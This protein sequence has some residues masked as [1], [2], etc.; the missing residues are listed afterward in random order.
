MTRIRNFVTILALACVFLAIPTAIRAQRGVDPTGE[1]R[2]VPLPAFLEQFKN[3]DPRIRARAF[4]SLLEPA[5]RANK[6]V[7]AE[8]ASEREL[9]TDALIALLRREAA[10]MHSPPTGENSEEFLDYVGD[11]VV[12]VA[13]LDSPKAVEALIGVIETGWGAMNG[14]VRLGKVA[15]PSLLRVADS[16]S[17][18]VRASAA[19]T[20]GRM[21][22]KHAE[23]GLGQND[24]ANIRT[25]LLARSADSDPY[26]R[27]GAIRSLMPFRDKEVMAAVRRAAEDSFAQRNGGEPVFPV[28]DAAQAWLRGKN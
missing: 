12:T 13:S 26:V 20:L 28:R 3:A 15:L 21:A 24:V 22:E 10:L 4:Y 23:V 27:A 11:L 5:Q 18:G 6:T 16:T 25:K 19:Y 2:Y 14:L 17:P 1:R 7:L 9:I 8:R